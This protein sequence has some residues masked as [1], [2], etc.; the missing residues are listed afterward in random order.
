MG[1]IAVVSLTEVSGMT[2]GR[3]PSMT[4]TQ[5]EPASEAPAP[6]DRPIASG[7]PSSTS[8]TWTSSRND[9]SHAVSRPKRRRS[10]LNIVRIRST[11]V[12][13]SAAGSPP[14]PSTSMAKMLDA[15]RSRG[16]INDD[17]DTCPNV[18]RYPQLSRVVHRLTG[19]GPRHRQHPGRQT[20]MPGGPREIRAGRG[21]WRT[22]R[23]SKGL[24]CHSAGVA[25]PPWSNA[26]A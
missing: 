16:G 2:E 15:T 8:N 10:T 21:G 17:I 26:S 18:A 25:S 9:D 24:A 11:G 12:S 20:Q 5:Y 7:F 19:A 4:R 6:R 14:A 3:R 22:D 13:D 23:S 1:R